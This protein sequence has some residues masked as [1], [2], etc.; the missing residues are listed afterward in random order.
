MKNFIF[1]SL[2]IFSFIS[3]YKDEPVTYFRDTVSE[4]EMIKDKSDVV[5]AK[6]LQ[7]VNPC[8]DI[9][10]PV[11]LKTNFNDTLDIKSYDDFNNVIDSLKSKHSL[12]Y[13]LTLIYPYTILKSNYDLIEVED[14]VEF[15][16]LNDSCGGIFSYLHD[17]LKRKTRLFYCYEI[18]PTYV[19]TWFEISSIYSNGPIKTIWPYAENILFERLKYLQNKYPDRSPI[20]KL[21][22]PIVIKKSNG[23]KI[24]VRD[25]SIIDE[26]RKN[27][28]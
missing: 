23:E 10:F 4:R 25:L 8:Y 22:L 21:V 28:Q 18:I 20:P 19:V 24:V 5:K 2:V 13:D 16:Q 3:C 11:K 15:N 6:S 27:C 26:I 17:S 9:F 7:N 12:D 1:Y 14:E